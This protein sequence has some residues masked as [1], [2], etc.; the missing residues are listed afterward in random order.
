MRRRALAPGLAAVAAVA[1]I[2]AAG[3][4]DARAAAPAAITVDARPGQVARVAAGLTRG[5]LK[6]QRR[7]G[8]RLQVVAEPRRAAALA[9]IPGVAG[10]R[11][12]TAAF[13]DD[14]ALSQG[15][16][17]SGADVLGRVANR[18]AGL[19]IAVLDL[20]FGEHI[21]RMQ[22]LGE[23]PP[24]E[25]LETLSFD[26][27]SGLAGRN[28]YGNRT[29]HGEIVSQTVYDYAPDARY[30]F[31]NYHSEADFLAAT[32]ALIAR[33]PDIVVHSNSFIEGPFDGTG[34]L[35]RAVDRAAA[36]GILW[37]NS[38]GN[39][40]RLHWGG[41]WAD[42]DADADLDWPNGDNWL[43]PRSAGQPV[44][45]ALSWVSPAGGPPTD[46]DL[47]LE[48][49]DASGA[50]TAVAASADRQ[51]QGLPT[52]ERIVGYS[53]PMDGVYR[54]RVVRVSG[55]P[56]AGE[57]TLFSREIP[58]AVIG[59]VAASSIPT[60]GD[61]AGAVAIGAVDWRGNAFKSYSSQGPTDDGRLKPDLV[62]PTDTRILGPSGFRSVGGTSNAAPN[63]AGAAAIVLAAERRAG[64][65][66]T[67][68]GVR[69][70]LEA[71]ALDLGVPGPDE[72]FGAGRVRVSADPP[73]VARPTPPPLA[74]VRGRVAVTFA[75]LSRSRIAT[76]TLAVDGR[77]AVPRPQSYPRGITIDTR[78]LADGWHA[79]HATARDWPGN[80]GSL[81]WSVKVD[82]TRPALI[83][84]RAVVT[85]PRRRPPSAKGP[86]LRPRTVKL[87]VALADAGSTGRLETT[88]T[89]AR[90]GGRRTPA[91]VVAV[92]PGP[93]RTITVGRLTRG[94]YSVRIMLHDRA[95]NSTTVTRGVTV[96]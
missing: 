1:V 47:A 79:L 31:V 43:F 64:R 14:V 49:Q 42:A 17:R 51:S 37:F 38:A 57:L 84:R 44:T 59:G 40:A 21:A 72:V 9:R 66:P 71:L 30:I 54:L 56:P 62:A 95:G 19:V 92:A 70:T 12:A 89:A 50:W 36:A 74:S 96:R 88:V 68:A 32:D 75:G 3:P 48:R 27:A 45:F 73:R 46:L 41:A 61:A 52:A 82:N 22:T 13:G 78:H 35:A 81:D 80:T 76:W 4:A 18:G 26:A 90:R 5:G 29:N 65:P 87:V 16:E 39:Y 15:I 91:R 6:V 93:L 20:G 11:P 67:A 33:R 77:P 83:V 60:P 8:R 10:A 94:S 58:L 7:V 24:P 28:A 69:A 85:R 53:P 63:A 55:P 23:L 34:P 25:R 86:D 2:A